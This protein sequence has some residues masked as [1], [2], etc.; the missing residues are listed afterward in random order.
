MF[1]ISGS[2]KESEINYNA[3][4]KDKCKYNQ[5]RID[6]LSVNLNSR[7]FNDDDDTERNKG[8]VDN[9]QEVISNMKNKYRLSTRNKNENDNETSKRI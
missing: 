8:K 3:D 1:K 7:K 6:Q 9:T 5:K 2:V 4:G